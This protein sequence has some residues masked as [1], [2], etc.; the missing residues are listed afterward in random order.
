MVD[1]VPTDDGVP[2]VGQESAGD[3]LQVRIAELIDESSGLS[4]P[5]ADWSAAVAIELAE[6]LLTPEQAQQRV[7]EEGSVQTLNLAL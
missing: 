2:P 6:Q 1:P 3:G 5:S 7:G 4:R